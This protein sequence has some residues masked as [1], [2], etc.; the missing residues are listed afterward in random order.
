MEQHLCY[1][2][3]E[4]EKD[5]QEHQAVYEINHRYGHETSP[6]IRRIEALQDAVK[7][8]RC[9]IAILAPKGSDQ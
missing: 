6:S 5:I 4:L 1:I 8:F 2:I 7:V 9:I 3:A